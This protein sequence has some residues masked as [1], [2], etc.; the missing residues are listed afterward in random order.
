MGTSARS[1]EVPP[2]RQNTTIHQSITYSALALEITH[3]SAGGALANTV[4]STADSGNTAPP[5]TTH[6]TNLPNT[7]NNRHHPT[8]TTN[9]PTTSH[10]WHARNRRPPKG[11]PRPA[12]TPTTPTPTDHHETRQPP[13]ITY[14]TL[15][16]GN[17]NAANTH[18]TIN[19]TTNPTNDGPRCR[20]LQHP[21]HHHHDPGTK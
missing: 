4:T 2:P 1:G 7:G 6:S 20:Q 8:S 21:Y 9:R 5:P 14:G 3:S 19:T 15:T 17:T 11:R 12:A 16:I 18:G 10:G 13:S